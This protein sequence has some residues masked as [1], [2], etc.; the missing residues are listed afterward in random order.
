[1]R[2]FIFVGAKVLAAGD[3]V[4]AQSPAAKKNMFHFLRLFHFCSA[5]I[6]TYIMIYRLADCNENETLVISDIKLTGEEAEKL[7]KLGLF[8]GEK[9]FI[10]K[11]FG[12]FVIVVNAEGASIALGREVAEKIFVKRGEL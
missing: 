4:K 9:V 6:I 11:I 10:E 12:K 7:D 8:I 3:C 5:N 2:F 1:M